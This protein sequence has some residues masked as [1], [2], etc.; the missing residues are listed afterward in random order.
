M[1]KKIIVAIL[2][3]VMVFSILPALPVDFMQAEAAGTTALENGYYYIYNAED[4]RYMTLQPD[5][6]YDPYDTSIT[7]SGYNIGGESFRK[8]DAAQIWRFV[9]LSEDGHNA[10]IIYSDHSS[11]SSH[12]M[13]VRGTT[14]VENF[15]NVYAYPSYISSQDNQ[16]F[17]LTAY[18]GGY[19]MR[20]LYNFTDT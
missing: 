2:M 1:A 5:V 7:L 9:K 10:Y 17:V 20:P 18:N 11:Y 14:Y 13:D 15:T 6:Q 3:F 19:S 16:E 8:G 4:D 12:C